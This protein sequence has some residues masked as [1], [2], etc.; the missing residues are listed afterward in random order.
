MQFWES[1]KND[2]GAGGGSGVQRGSLAL[3]KLQEGEEVSNLGGE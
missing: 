2:G 3:N 1:M